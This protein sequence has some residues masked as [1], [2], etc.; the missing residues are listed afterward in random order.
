MDSLF[1]HNYNNTQIRSRYYFSSESH[2]LTFLNLLRFGNN[3]S[4]FSEKT[5]NLIDTEIK[6]MNYLSQIV[7]QLYEIEDANNNSNK[8]NSIDERSRFFI[9]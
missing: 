5:Q 8:R 3:G 9:K 2:L 4:L 1:I 6:E 7:L